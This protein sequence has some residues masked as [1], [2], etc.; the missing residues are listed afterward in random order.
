MDL[1]HIPLLRL[2]L[3]HHL[4]RPA[5]DHV[6]RP[7][8]RQ[9]AVIVVENAPGVEQRDR[10]SEQLFHHEL[11]FV[12]QWVPVRLHLVIEIVFAKREHWD[13]VGARA[14]RELYEAFAAFEDEAEAVGEGVEGFAGAAN[15]DC[16]CAAHAFAVGA[17][18]GK[19]ILAALARDGGEAQGEGVVAVQ[20]Y[21]EVGVEGEEGV[22]DAR[23]QLAK[24]QGF[25]GEGGEGAVRDDAVWVVAE[26]V[27]AGW[28]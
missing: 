5:H 16:D 9:H 28:G 27:F 6:Q 26:D 13:E 4:N 23:E 8:V 17:A 12:H 18:A 21:A 10:E 11:R 22:C 2:D 20:G 25:G 7:P 14:D 15:D 3:L 1:I 24:S 19:D